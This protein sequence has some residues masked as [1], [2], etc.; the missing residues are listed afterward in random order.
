MSLSWQPGWI[1][2]TALQRQVEEEGLFRLLDKQQSILVGEGIKVDNGLAATVLSRHKVVHYLADPNAVGQGDK[3]RQPILDGVSFR[4]TV[5]VS[6]DRRIVHLTLTEK[7]ADLE[8]IDRVTLIGDG[9]KEV[10]VETPIVKE[11]THTEVNNIP[12]GGS[13]LMP[14]DYRPRSL[15]AKNRWWVLAH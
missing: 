12:D 6:S 8:T 7:A 5:Q 1:A 13:L 14:V 11:S 9:E 3:T 10:E 4:A 15:A 2:R